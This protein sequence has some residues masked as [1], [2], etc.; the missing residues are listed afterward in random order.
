M[1][2]V[3]S[4]NTKRYSVAIA[5][6]ST[7]MLTYSLGAVA[8]TSSFSQDHN[9]RSVGSFAKTVREARQRGIPLSD[10]IETTRGSDIER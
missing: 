8:E 4:G 7:F 3:L 9:C 1:S 2:E 6:V 10:L 5:T